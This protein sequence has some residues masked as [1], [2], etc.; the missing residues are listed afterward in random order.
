M[1]SLTFIRENDGLA[2]RVPHGYDSLRKREWVSNPPHLD[3]K[4][5]Q[6]YKTKMVPSNNLLQEVS[7]SSTELSDVK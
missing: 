2:S 5:A 4:C 7:G 1:L 3:K 6:A